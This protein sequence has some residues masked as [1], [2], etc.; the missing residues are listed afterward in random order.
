MNTNYTVVEVAD[1]TVNAFDYLRTDAKGFALFEKILGK[2]LDIRSFKLDD[3]VADTKTEYYWHLDI[4]SGWSISVFIND[5][6]YTSSQ[7]SNHDLNLDIEFKYNGSCNGYAGVYFA[8]GIVDTE[9]SSSPT[10]VFKSIIASVKRRVTITYREHLKY[11]A[12]SQYYDK[13]VKEFNI[14]IK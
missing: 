13:L 11:M 3:Y 1:A 6:V 9:D 10:E 14:K 2:P 8:N 12:N 7:G 5:M 4:G